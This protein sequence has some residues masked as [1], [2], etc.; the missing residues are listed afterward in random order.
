[1]EDRYIVIRWPWIQRFM[2][3]EGFAD[4]SALINSEELYVEYGSSAYFVRESW[5]NSLATDPDFYD[6]LKL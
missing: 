5:I 1:M 4:N 3:F 2:E 6:D